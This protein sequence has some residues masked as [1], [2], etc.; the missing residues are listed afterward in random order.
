MQVHTNLWG[1]RMALEKKIFK[2]VEV[3]FVVGSVDPTVTAKETFTIMDLNCMGI[4]LE[5]FY[6]Q[7]GMYKMV[8][9]GELEVVQKELE[10][11]QKDGR[12]GMVIL[13]EPGV[14]EPA[15][16]IIIILPNCL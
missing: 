10:R 2:N 3:P 4:S 1:Q 9:R 8:V 5:T 13:G 11:H 16:R 12:G 14:G 6:H 15:I 7:P